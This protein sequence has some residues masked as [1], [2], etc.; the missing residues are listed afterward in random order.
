MSSTWKRAPSSRAANLPRQRRI[1]V[2]TLRGC[3]G[4][5]GLAEL[6]RV[7]RAVLKAESVAPEVEAD[8]VIADAATVRDLNRLYRGRDETTD[9][10]SFAAQEGE[11][12]VHAPDEPPSLGEVVVCLPVAEEQAAAAGRPVGGEVAHL[13]VHGLLH[14]LGFDHEEPAE[15]AA[16]KARE[17]HIL[18]S[19]GYAGGYEHG[20]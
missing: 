8:V 15:A 14:V 3:G 9:V 19:L 16:M 7:A 4:R 5:I 2:R 10:L 13:V 17:D 12:F 18:E 1:N 6:R 20:H 11:A